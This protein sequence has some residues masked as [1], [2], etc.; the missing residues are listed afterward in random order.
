MILNIDI[1]MLIQIITDN[2]KY[3]NELNLRIPQALLH[4]ANNNL[5]INIFMGENKSNV[6]IF[7]DEEQILVTANEKEKQ[8]I[9]IL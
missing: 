8:L 4:V 7:S 3:T 9:R 2:H 6:I 5:L 1:L